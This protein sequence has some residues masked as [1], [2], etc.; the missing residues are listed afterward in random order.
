MKYGKTY[1]KYGHFGRIP[2][3]KN[4]ICIR[5]PCRGGTS[6]CTEVPRQCKTGAKDVR[7]FGPYKWTVALT[8]NEQLLSGV[9]GPAKS[10]K[11]HLHEHLSFP[12]WEHTPKTPSLSFV[13]YFS[14][15]S[16]KKTC[17]HIQRSRLFL[18][19]QSSFASLVKGRLFHLSVFY[20]I[21]STSFLWSN[22]ARAKWPMFMIKLEVIVMSRGISP[23]KTLWTLSVRFIKVL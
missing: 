14:T 3:F 4:V 21:L 15:L 17:V 6:R 1:K 11:Q 7:T 8:T 12:I 18:K 2:G 23:V 5:I 16:A 22:L 9:L 19:T 13:S 10:E 20:M